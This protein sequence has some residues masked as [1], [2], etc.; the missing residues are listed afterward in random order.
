M[1]FSEVVDGLKA[2]VISIGVSDQV[3]YYVVV[4]NCGYEKTVKGLV[5][6]INEMI[7]ELAEGEYDDG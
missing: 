5:N 3:T 2:E 7:A 6:T 1:N 4:A